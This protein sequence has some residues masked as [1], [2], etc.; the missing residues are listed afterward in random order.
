[1]TASRGPEPPRWDRLSEAE[2]EAAVARDPVVVLPLAATEQHGP[3]LPLSTDVDIGM[4]L[5]VEAFAGLPTPIAAWTLPVVAVGASLEHARFPGTESVSADELVRI[6]V[7][8]GTA[9]ADAGVRRLV[10]SNSHGGNRFAMESAGLLLRE[11]HDMLVVKVS[12]PRLGRPDG[13]DLPEVEWRHGLHGGAV[14][15]AMMLHARP[16]LVRADAIADFASLGADLEVALRRVGPE[17]EASFSWLAGDLNPRGVVGDAT[18]ATAAM[19]E[20][21]VRYYGAVLAEVI[22]DAADFP[23]D[24]LV[25]AGTS[26]SA[27]VGAVL[28]E[29]AAW[30]LLRAARSATPGSG[31]GGRPDT[32]TVESE[33]APR[34]RL[35]LHADG[36]WTADAPPTE[37]AKKLLD[38]FAAIV[39]VPEIVIGQ[40]GQS[41]DGRI[42]TESGA[43]HYVTGQQDLERLHRLRAL[44]DAV[45]V[46]TSTVAL[47]D[48]RLTV[49]LVEGADPVRVVLDPSGRIDA[50]SRV[51]S[52]VGGKTLVVRAAEGAAVES[53]TDANAAKGAYEVLRVPW[54]APGELDLS[55]LL[56]DL[57]ARGLR[58]ILVEGGGLTVSR[59]LECDLL[60]RLHVTVAPLL[61]GSGRPSL[62]LEPIVGLDEALRPAA[63]RF[64]LGEDV[65]FD[66]DLRAEPSGAP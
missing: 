61:I 34:L 5:L 38:V 27:D 29:R 63:R 31:S 36:T 37:G 59:F 43:S 7:D 14:E 15:T 45:V 44:V 35:E 19:G 24:R 54:S 51:L 22:L 8:T 32:T 6:I 47:D 39:A 28:D 4:A 48:P 33:S 62:T 30:E 20:R 56:A 11:R 58:R 10:L 21:L 17:G 52:E 1:M 40:L 53:G 41:L 49:R 2:R 13:V 12:W 50:A 3:H 64:S 18:L 42:A 65:L 55:R 9:V 16:D 46:G 26:G 60:D 25:R 23:L 57:R 66:L